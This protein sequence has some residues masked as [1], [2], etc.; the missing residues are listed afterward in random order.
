MAKFI[1]DYQVVT[2]FVDPGTTVLGLTME[3]F[4]SEVKRLIKEGWSLH[5]GV[6]ISSLQI[7]V[8]REIYSTPLCTGRVYSHILSPFVQTMVAQA[9]VLYAEP[10]ELEVIG[11]FDS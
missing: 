4:N 5:G 11:H 6:S 7:P 10:I 9:M 3:D 1:K 8:E 2:W